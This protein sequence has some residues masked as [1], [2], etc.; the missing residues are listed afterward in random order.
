M[1]WMISEDKLGQDQVEVIDEI[2]KISNK[3]IWIKGH[4]GSGKSVLLLHSLADYIVKNP[5]ANVCVV[6]FTRALVD[7]LRTGINQIP[8]LKGFTIPVVTIYQLKYRIDNGGIRYDAIFC[9]EIQDLPIEFINS[10]KSVCN[11]FVLAGDAEQ[12]IYQTVPIFNTA[13]AT[14]DE[15]LNN[16]TPIEKK[17]GVIYRLTDSVLKVL[18]NVFTSMLND[19]PNIAKVDTE[20]LIYKSD[21]KNNENEIRFCWQEIKNTN[22]LRVSDVCA[23]LICEHNSIVDFVNTVLQ[24]EG[25]NIWKRVDDKDRKPNYEILNAHLSKE[26]VPLMYVGNNY[27]SL[28]EAD[29]NNKI[30]IM[31][32]SSAKGLDFD[33]IFMP[34]VNSFM[35]IPS[36]IVNPLLL[37][38][39]SRSKS[40]LFISFTGEMYSGLKQ[41]LTGIDIKSIKEKSSKEIVF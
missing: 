26:S 3:P 11:H 18:R 30:V 38:A 13:P 36:A 12:S 9:D 27:G 34:M 15:I 25:K 23:I 2:G 39:L 1:Q 35:R 21:T 33:Y 5:K 20:I 19:M 16:I 32:Y 8:K 10:I 24:I 37:V 6:V 17:L 41:F 28:T 14:P 22:D 40:G 31:T 7:L 4:A 29:R